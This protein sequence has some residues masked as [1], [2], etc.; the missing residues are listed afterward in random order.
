MRGQGLGIPGPR[1]GCLVVEG[2]LAPFPDVIEAIRRYDVWRG[3]V[4][5]FVVDSELW[6]S[7]VGL[8]H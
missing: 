2:L 8:W 6:K 5:Q 3:L 1:L 4:A 7:G